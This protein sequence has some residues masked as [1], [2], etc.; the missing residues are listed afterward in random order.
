MAQN[1]EPEISE[2]QTA[3]ALIN[4]TISSKELAYRL[5]PLTKDQLEPLGSLFQ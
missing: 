2:V 5:V 4:P 3:A 1:S